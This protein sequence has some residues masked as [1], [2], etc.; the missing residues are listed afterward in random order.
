MQ[1]STI[2]SN[3]KIEQRELSCIPQNLIGITSGRSGRMPIRARLL[4][5]HKQELLLQGQSPL[6]YAIVGQHLNAAKVL[7]DAQ[8]DVRCSYKVR[9]SQ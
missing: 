1:L 3:S 9:K 4:A 6:I 8:A 2:S 5:P 7:L